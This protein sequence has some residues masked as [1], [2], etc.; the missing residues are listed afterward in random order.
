MKQTKKQNKPKKQDRIKIITI[1]QFL[2]VII[3]LITLIVKQ[4]IYKKQDETKQKAK[5][6]KNKQIKQ[7]KTK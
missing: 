7:N 2:H 1:K 4:I 5:Q 3:I 6:D